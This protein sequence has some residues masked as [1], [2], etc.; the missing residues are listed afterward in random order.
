MKLFTLIFVL[1]ASSLL[2]FCMA[3]PLNAG[4]SMSERKHSYNPQCFG[5]GGSPSPPPQQPATTAST[6]TTTTAASA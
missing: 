1:L 5:F 4:R 3:S 6:T 2:M